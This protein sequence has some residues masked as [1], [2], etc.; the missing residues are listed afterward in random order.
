MTVQ[1][2]N[3]SAKQHP[4]GLVVIARNATGQIVT[5]ITSRYDLPGAKLTAHSVLKLKLDAVCAEVH[6]NEGPT[7]EYQKKPLLIICK[8][9]LQTVQGATSL[10]T[11]VLAIFP[12]HDGCG[13]MNE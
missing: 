3:D 11:K 12:S 10:S 13:M 6:R 1:G 7:S 9:T 2:N 5:R 8:D 4:S